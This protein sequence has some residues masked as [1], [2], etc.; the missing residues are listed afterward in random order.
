MDFFMAASRCSKKGIMEIYPK[1]IVNESK[2][3]MIRGGDFYAIW[4][5][6]QNRWSRNENDAIRL[7]DRELDAKKEE[8]S[9]GF[10]GQVR[11]LHL[12]DA[13]TGMIDSWHRYCQKQ[14]RDNF[15]SLDE[16]II[17]SNTSFGKE[18]YSSHS[19]SYPLAQGDTSAFDEL[20]SVL[21]DEE[22][23]TK[24]EW[25]IGSVVNGDS[26]SIQ[27][28]LVLY[29]SAGTGKSTILNIIQMIFDG[30]YCVFDA[31]AL[32]SSSNAFALESFRTNPLV[33]IQHD[34]DLSKIED[35][36][37]LNSLVSHEPMVVNEKFKSTYTS[38]FNAMLFVGTNKPVKITDTKSGLLRRLID[39]KPTGEKI[40]R[41]RYLELMNRIKFEL[42]AICYKCK[43][44][45][46]SNKNLYDDYIPLEM[47]GA[48]NDFYNFIMDSY[49]I[50]ESKDSTTLRVAW[51]MY[52][53]YCDYAS[54]GYPYP[55][56]MFKEE[57]KNYFY[58]FKERAYLDDNTFARNVYSGFKKEKFNVT[59]TCDGNN[60]ISTTFYDFTRQDSV[61][62]DILKDCPAQYAVG[63]GTPS[64]RWDECTTTL[65]DISTEELHYVRPPLNH[66]VID[67]DIKG[68]D[69]KKSL[70]KNVEAMKK[71]PPSY[72]E[73]S[74]S[75]KGIHLHYIYDGDPTELASVY[76]DGIEIKVFKGNSALRR[77]KTKCNSLDISVISGGLPLK[78]KKKV[79]TEKQVKSEKGLRALVYSNLKKDI[80]PSTKSSIDFIYKILDDAYNSELEYDIS[81]LKPKVIAFAA[82]STN[83]SG[84]CLKLVTKM[85]F[86]SK[87]M[88][89]TE[90]FAD[91]KLYFFDVEV[92]PNLFLVCIKEQGEGKEVKRYFN[93]T[94]EQVGELIEKKLIGFNCRRY[95]NHI[96]YGCYLGDSNK[97]IYNRSKRIIEGDRSG[98]I[99]RAYNLS[100]T[101]IYD[102]SSKKQ[103]LKKFEIELGIHHKE[104]EYDWNKDI[105]EDK[106]DE[107]AS[108][109]DNDVLATEAV[110]DARQADFTARKILADVAG[111]TVNDTTNSLT[112]KIIFGNDRNPQAQFNYRDL[113][114]TFNG[115][116]FENGKSTYRGEEVGEGGY[117]YSEPGMYENVALLDI[118]SMHPSSIVAENLFGDIYT[119]RFEELM[120]ARIAIKHKQFDRAKEML[121][122]KLQLY[123]TDETQ[124]NDLAKALKI[125]INSVYGLTAASFDNPFRDPRNIDNIVAK[126]G[127]LFMVDLKHAVQEQGY[128]VAHIKTDS[129]KIPNADDY[130]INF[131]TEYGKKFGYNFEHEATYDKLCLVNDAVYVAKEKDIWTA[132]GAQ[133]QVPFVFKTLFSKEPI[134]FDDMCE[135]RSVT[136]SMYLRYSDHTDFVGKVGL[137]CPMKDIGGELVRE[138]DGKFYAVTGT[139]GYLFM[140]AEDVKKNHLESHIDKSYYISLVEQAKETIEKFGDYYMFSSD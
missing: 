106:W 138:K 99:G 105:P 19:L 29:G 83:N 70:E 32:G 88:E 31:K 66:I 25:A 30:Y 9:D 42:G 121:D 55:Q 57:L 1:F 84:Y 11:V 38:Y 91:D 78:E 65:K 58:T 56:R 4:D 50:F 24:I 135:T 104:L 51:D 127:A 73:L 68:D 112:T 119:K 67:F 123:L 17:F 6:D 61:L 124:A 20:I 36:T 49:D 90:N 60:D 75:E 2:D 107:V 118:A 34:G 139:K 59:A 8:L 93:P 76:D 100:Y 46:E 120:M 53:N 133:F 15:R 96:L 98:F 72:A 117:V 33:A 23:R 5:E 22:N 126:R 41:E 43:E 80:H 54:V 85:N 82:K 18:D 86:K 64:M 108:Y 130:I 48:T 35:N 111:M 63:T 92:F 113:S 26:K 12:W 114:T 40:A 74:K 136:S 71:F 27:K 137:F 77:K 52:K 116:S 129:I 109:C 95:D 102:F 89:N 140:E 62:D 87:S 45:Y 79:I 14:L 94:Q 134:I 16:K 131:V 101:D 44:I 39:V 7:I 97:D 10:E 115:Y 28:F 132:T 128:V 103:S 47:I 122:G 37:R 81:D 3:L 110:F 125:A 21:Y 69:G 13:E